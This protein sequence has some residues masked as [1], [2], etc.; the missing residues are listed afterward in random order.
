MGLRFL[1]EPSALVKGA[2]EVSLRLGGQSAVNTD[3]ILPRNQQGCC[4]H[5]AASAQRTKA[6]DR[7]R[8]EERK[9]RNRREFSNCNHNARVERSIT[10]LIWNI[11][12][13]LKP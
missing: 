13:R 7:V 1:S 2:L 5:C 3:S 12:F 8:G 4:Q 6:T 9:S 10:G 11:L